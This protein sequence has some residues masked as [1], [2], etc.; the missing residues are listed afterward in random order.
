MTNRQRLEKLPT[1]EF[2]EALRDV[3]RRQNKYTDLEA[4]FEG[5]DEDLMHYIKA[6]G[7]VTTVPSEYEVKAY[8]NERRAAGKPVDKGILDAYIKDHTRIYPHLDDVT[9]LG[10]KYVVVY[11]TDTQCITK[12]PATNIAE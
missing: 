11:N 9:M 7:L 4:W 12:I 6:K 10:T 2:V 1:H 8:E 3:F 5:E